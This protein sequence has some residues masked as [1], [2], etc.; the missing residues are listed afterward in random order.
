MD[1]SPVIEQ[2]SGEDEA[3]AIDAVVLWV[4]GNDPVQRAAL[5][6]WQ[7][8]QP[9]LRPRQFRYRNNGE[10]RYALRSIHFHM[11]WLRTI[12]LVTNGQVPA[13][14]D[15]S[16]PGIRLVKHADFFRRA[17]DLPTFSSIAIEANLTWIGRAAVARRFL[18]FNDD[19][20]VGRPTPREAFVAKDGG[21]I[22]HVWNSPLPP[23]RRDLDLY[24]TML[25][26]NSALL[27]WTFGRKP[28]NDL[29]HAPLIM[30]RDDLAWLDKTF[31]YWLRRTSRHRFRR[32]TDV[33]IRL[34]YVHAVAERDAGRR[35]GARRIV[36]SNEDFGFTAVRD[37]DDF[38]RS[39]ARLVETSPSFFCLNDE[40]EDDA[41]AT[42]RAADMCR[43][44]AKIFPTRAP[45]E[46]EI[47]D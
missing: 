45:F 22:F 20:F 18:L 1:N 31:A 16:H 12:H 9:W 29:P 47:S 25:A 40:I 13:W 7:P 33:C 5:S 17:A 41:R 2:R 34:L 46:R 36:V 10:L 11:P 23:L 27:S 6:R 26:F 44:L 37:D 14:L 42:V 38:S 24:I 4:D 43:A 19:T 35:G 21:Q 15:T 8:I 30:D 3:A 32:R 28:W 39:L